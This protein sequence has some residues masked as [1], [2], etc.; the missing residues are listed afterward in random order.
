MYILLLIWGKV[1]T[2]KW[3]CWLIFSHFWGPSTLATPFGIPTSSAQGFQVVRICHQ[4]LSSDS[5]MVAVLMGVRWGSHCGFALHF[6]KA[7][8]CWAS[9]HTLLATCVF[10]LELKLLLQKQRM[11]CSEKGALPAI[12]GN[13]LP[14][15][16]RW[17]LAMSGD[18]FSCLDW[19]KETSLVVQW[20]RLQFPMEGMG[21]WCL[22]EKLRSHMLHGQKT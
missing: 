4:H 18:I 14:L 12:W 10:P 2:W 9:F 20:L 3:N 22:V 1:C 19:R 5:V 17:H 15:T 8:W 7:W 13:S 16:P 6:P 21:I 11:P